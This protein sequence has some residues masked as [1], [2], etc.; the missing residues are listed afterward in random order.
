MFWGVL[1]GGLGYGYYLY[2]KRAKRV[3]PLVVGILLMV[4][5][6]LIY[7]STTLVAVSVALCAVPYFVRG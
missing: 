7:E 4:L 3:I 5:P 1:W 2:G 6:Y